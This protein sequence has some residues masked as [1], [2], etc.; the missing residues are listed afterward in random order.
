MKTVYQLIEVLQNLDIHLYEFDG[1]IR[2]RDTHNRLTDQHRQQIRRLR[3]PLLEFLSDSST[4]VT[5]IDLIRP[6]ASTAPPPLSFA[7]QRLWFLD[8][9]EPESAFYNI[10]TLLR[11]TGQLDV[12]ALEESFR[13]LIERHESLRTIFGPHS[14]RNR[15]GVLPP[16]NLPHSGGGTDTSTAKLRLPPHVGEGW[17]GV[18]H[19]GEAYQLI[20]PPS[21][22]AQFTLAI[23]PVADEGEAQRLAQIEATTPFDLSEG[24]LL[25]V[26]LL[27]IA[28]V[29]SS[30]SS[31]GSLTGSEMRF[32]LVINMHHIISDGWSMD[33]LVRELTHAYRAYTVG[34]QPTLPDLPIQYADF[35]LWQRDYLSGERLEAQLAYWRT[36]LAGAPALL[37][38]PTDRPR[39][40]KQSYRG[41]HYAFELN[42]DLTAKLNQ[43]A[44]AHDA[45]LFMVILAAFNV[46]LARYSRQD[47]IV[48]GSPIANR[49]RAEI[50]GLIGVF[51][52]S[53]VLRTQLEDN[54]SFTELLAQV[55]QTTLDAYQHQDLPFEQLVDALALTRSL[56]YSP[57]FQVMLV[58]QNA[59]MVEFDLSTPSS[60]GTSLIATMQPA[61]SASAKFDIT[62]NLIEQ[63]KEDGLQGII[64]Y[65]TDLFEESTIARLASYFTV[66]L[67]GV[68]SQPEQPV[69]QLPMLTGAEYHQIVHEWNDTAVDFGE[70]QTIHALFEGQVKRTPNAVA[71]IFENEQL[72]Y[73]ELN[74][75][76]H[77][78]AHHLIEL[79]VYADT[80]VAVSMERSIEI[81]VSLLAILKA[82]GAYVPIDPT[83][84]KERIHYMLADSAAPILLT[85]SH[86]PLASF[87]GDDG[88]EGST[89]QSMHVL[90]VDAMM[91]TWAAQPTANPQTPTLRAQRAPAQ[92][93][94]SVDDLAYVIYTSGSTGQ[95]KG[96]A[97]PHGNLYNLVRDNIERFA[98]AEDS[99]VMHAPT[100]GFDVEV[101]DLFMT[102]CSGA[103][104]Y[105]PIPEK[106]VGSFLG[107]QLRQSKATHVSLTPTALSTLPV[108]PYPH[109]QQMIVAGEALPDALTQSWLPHTSVWNAYGPTENTIY[110]TAARCQIGEKVHIGRPT[111]NVK[112]F[113]L[114]NAGN[115]VPMG[116]AGELHIGGAQLA[117]EYLN[118]PELTAERFI[119]HPEFGRLYKTGDLC[120]WLLDGNIEYI[121]R[122]DFQ[123]KLRGF[124]IELG[125]IENALLAQDGVREAVV[126]ARAEKGDKRLVAYLVA[127][128]KS[129]KVEGGKVEGN[130]T[131]PS[132]LKPFNPST[133][134]QTLAQQLPDYMIPAAFVFLDAMPLSPNGKLDRGALAGHPLEPD[135]NAATTTNYVMPQSAIERQIVEIWQTL[136]Q[137]ERVGL[138]DNFFELGGHS[139]LTIHV[140]QQ[141]KTLY[142]YNVSVTDLFQY[143]TVHQLATY[144]QQ[145][146]NI[147][148]ESPTLNRTSIH[149][150]VEDHIQNQN[151]DIA[152]IGMACRFPDVDSVD[153]FWEK[154][155]DGI[156][157]VSTFSDEELLAAGVDQTL[158]ENPAYVNVGAR[159]A[160]AAQF[161][162][163]FFGFTPNEARLLDPQHRFFLECAQTALDDAGYDPATYDDAIGVYAGAGMNTYLHNNLSFAE[164]MD[165]SVKI[166]QHAISN[167]KDYL[168]TQVSYRLNLKGPSVNVQTACSTSLVAVHL[169]TQSLLNGECQ[170]ALAG[171][172]SIPFPQDRG[173]LYQEGMIM[174]PDGHCRAFDAKAQGTVGGC[175][176]G[177]V[178]LKRAE[179]ALKDGDVI[180]AI[181][182]GTA[183]NNDGSAKMNYTAPS[184]DGQRSVIRAAQHAAGVEAETISYIE[185]HGTGTKIGDP[186]EIAALTQAFQSEKRGFCA[187][188]SV[189]TNMGHADA[190]AGIAGLI[191]TVLSLKH[192]LLPPTLHFS[193]PNPEIDFANSPFYVNSELSTWQ[194]TDGTPR[195]AGISSF[196]I[197]GTNAHVIVEEAPAADALPSSSRPVQLLML[198]AK[199]ESA[200]ATMSAT[201]AD[202][203]S[204]H[205]ENSLSDTAYTLQVGRQRHPHRQVWIGQN[206]K[207]AIQHLQTTEQVMDGVHEQ[208]YSPI[209]FMFPGGGVQHIEMGADLYTHEPVF[210]K[211]MNQCAVWL[212]PHL[213]VNICQLIY[214]STDELSSEHHR[215]EH[216]FKQTKFALPLLFATEYALAQLLMSWGIQPRAMI[217]HSMGEYVA[218]CLADVFTLED[219]LSLVLK[220]GQLFDELPSGS[221]LSVTLSV[222][223]LQPYLGDHLSIAATNAPTLCT[224]AGPTEEIMKLA[225]SLTADQV[226]YRHI[227]IA[228]AA[229][230][231]ML[232]PI[233]ERFHAFVS[234]ISLSPP[235]IPFISNLT[236]RW[237]RSEEAIA[238]SYWVNHLRHTVRFTDGIKTLLEEEDGIFLEV[239]PGHALTSL[240][241][242]HPMHPTQTALATMR[243]P[244]K[245]QSD[246]ECLLSAIAQTWIAGGVIDWDGFYQHEERRRLSLPTY[247]FERQKYWVDVPKRRRGVEQL[248]P[249]IDTMSRLP[250]DGKILFETDVSTDTLPFLQDHVVYDTVVSPG[251][252]HLSMVLSAG[253]LAWQKRIQPRQCYELSDVILP[254][255]L[256]LD[257]GQN[258]LAQ[259]VLTPL[260]EQ[261]Q[262]T[263]AQFQLI[264]FEPEMDLLEQDATMTHAMGVVGLKEP[265][266]EQSFSNG[267]RLREIQTYCQQLV[268]VP[269]VVDEFGTFMGASFRWIDAVWH[270]TT[271]NGMPPEE[272]LTQL[273]CPDVI[274]DLK[275]Y[276]IHPGLLDACFQTAALAREMSETEDASDVVLPFAVNSLQL[277]A[278][279]NQTAAVESSPSRTWWCHAKKI[280]PL[281]WDIHLFDMSGAVVAKIDGFEM[282]KASASAIHTTRLRTEWLQH[283][284]WQAEPLT[285]PTGKR[286][287]CW[288]IVGLLSEV[289]EALAEALAASRQ[290]KVLPVYCLDASA[291]KSDIAHQLIE[292]ASQHRAIGVVYLGIHAESGPAEAVA[293]DALALC[294]GL[295]HLTQSLVEHEIETQLWIATQGCQGVSMETAIA[296][297]PPPNLPQSGGGTETVPYPVWRG[298]THDQVGATAAAGTLWGFGRSLMHEHPRLNTVCVDLGAYDD[299]H[300]QV[301]ALVAELATELVNSYG[302]LSQA[303]E[304]AYQQQTRYVAQ[305]NTWELPT[306]DVRVPLL[307]QLSAYGLLDHLTFVPQTRQRPQPDEIEVAVC[308]AG[309][310]FRDVLN[311]LGMF[312]A[313]YAA[314]GVT[315]AKDVGL[316]S[317]YVG[318]VSAVGTDVTHIAVGDRVMGLA[319]REGTFANYMTIPAERAVPIPDGVN[320]EE[321]A[322]IPLAFLTAWYGLVTLAKLQP[323][324]RILIHA[325]AGGV[326]QAAAQIAQAI[327]AEVIA[328]ASPNKQPFL[329]EQ[330]IQHVANSRTLEFVDEILALTDGKG[331]DVVLNSLN[332]SF[333]DASFDILAQ[334]G[335]FVEIGR[336]DIWSHEEVAQRRPDATY[337]PFDLSE[338]MAAD[339]GLETRLWAELTVQF[340]MGRL[341][342]LP[343]VT[344]P[345]AD[346]IAAF[347]YMQQAQHIGKIVLHI[348]PPALPESPRAEY[349]QDQSA[350]V[351]VDTVEVDIIHSDAT[352]LVTGGL[353]ALGLQVAQQ[354]VEEG[355]KHLV[356]TGRRGVTSA[357]QQE[358]IDALQQQGA[359][360][361]VVAADIA[362]REDARRVLDECTAI[363]PLRGIIHAA[364]L[365]D[366]GVLTAQTPERF[367]T[368]M[369]PKVA[370]TWHLHTLT[371]EMDLDF[372]VC[373]SSIGSLLG[374]AGQSNYAAA[375]AFM[376]TLMRQRHVLDL[377]GLSINWGAWSDVGLAAHL[378]EKAQLQ[379]LGMISPQQGRHLTSYLLQQPA[380]NIGGQIGV[381]PRQVAPRQYRATTPVADKSER[382]LRERLAELP[383]EE[384]RAYLDIQ[385]H[386][387]LIAVL[388]LRSESMISHDA[389]L[390]DVGLD[391]LTAIELKNR[392]SAKLDVALPATIL[393]DY[394]TLDVLGHYLLHDVLALS[395]ESGNGENPD[396]IASTTKHRNIGDDIDMA[397]PQ[398]DTEL[399]SL[400]KDELTDILAAKLDRLG[401]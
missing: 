248:R 106:L 374:S 346:A 250:L 40:P 58:L 184:V 170:M 113:I 79:G 160:D 54:P 80:L 72:T 53:L 280:T 68:V 277:Y 17:G 92:S 300:T 201:L 307:L 27:Q 3:V 20:H 314:L 286:P 272:V 45:T 151:R 240:V 364:G 185:A 306:K 9:M 391:S 189:K 7:Q 13:Y 264:S 323:G 327:G 99:C 253:E 276:I 396:S 63:G 242:Q 192:G 42:A 169:A 152:V 51:A 338:E 258:R 67:E 269:S 76:A 172:V 360:V 55:R 134:R 293:D 383:V 362:D 344:F 278:Q 339:N 95:P 340:G 392:L 44:Q 187:I 224:V 245:K 358:A 279:T 261:H 375:N 267:T 294:T 25:R 386:H 353:G 366:D 148:S 291:Q 147:E 31:A 168:P 94:A 216:E 273:R 370:G 19:D 60:L 289:S 236:G 284:T 348:E 162:A 321:A 377:P 125:E 363:A 23:T 389:R 70:P 153:E 32:L 379:G 342:P 1:K 296:V 114:G 128:L 118:R 87:T 223:A 30:A 308:A 275:G 73:H 15:G 179:D 207:D 254:Q 57:L 369:R 357:E 244:R 226:S 247:P 145:K 130:D 194:T 205:P 191:K 315:E 88:V 297:P 262:G 173:Y 188:G 115:P 215:F 86:L 158:L 204:Q 349:A 105:L 270:P 310:N 39:P 298:T 37:E 394:P 21:W 195:R 104:L 165:D 230:S 66:L 241:K 367:E 399:E 234:T 332:G 249:L 93:T 177:I 345:F 85:Q 203:L 164:S 10:P 268:Q 107:E 89:S 231:A 29:V 337:Y 198:S 336:I 14:S 281:K 341:K 98:V 287:D 398:M 190:A 62:L 324:E 65:A 163:H 52:N 11:L 81:V 171:G 354:L 112:T 48:V 395:I 122:T 46:L 91:T 12:A 176:V 237:I 311:A 124:R 282:R 78:L 22:A 331:V 384:Q 200:L 220:R 211:A 26:Q 381:V 343:K 397:A 161:D 214:Q 108:E 208:N 140:Q 117:R 210:R 209:L 103:K 38:L 401:V 97:I 372:F 183:I 313:H 82:G 330:G 142:A 312:E 5:A 365:I 373:F 355:A 166:F 229:H 239:G 129:G 387:E 119:N 24:P 181:I 292:I 116:I 149:S 50:E 309:L 255:A 8:K 228:V 102:L 193:A 100:F 146:N 225:E 382:E 83:Y 127:E 34:Q 178:V 4:S 28:D 109:L 350:I 320:D 243:H 227:H 150:H 334:Q 120:R 35:A 47:D 235:T 285:E 376:D 238:P 101:G 75:R 174:S 96:V 303:R 43:L 144:L 110:T 186:I 266:F 137:V 218:A 156:E 251:A 335:R 305:L 368:V 371:T 59:E 219:A 84:P 202:Y 16:P 136:I 6:R 304:V 328:T 333:I 322:T 157:L 347:R 259:T 260:Q 393:F 326:G 131:D 132:T 390:F 378:T 257:E 301:S 290:S 49:N 182:K 318:I 18:D 167:D 141:L 252:C 135:A 111:A 232:T 400:S 197:G 90:A 2:V 71:L 154:L 317:E 351:E 139:L 143:P 77:Q 121:G 233:L 33:V 263:Q 212:E 380:S 356:L 196:G 283:I 274:G 352:Y 222:E 265:S 36:Q 41:A 213:G 316:G 217:G 126:L 155:R 329:R 138:Y 246:I 159:I 302:H 175:G 359:V 388:G 133:L 271:D 299:T 206:Q 288:V 199:T 325:A 319:A 256:A 180:H 56:S 123:V 64:E 74:E 69:H 385:I 61:V 295:L 221:M 361:H